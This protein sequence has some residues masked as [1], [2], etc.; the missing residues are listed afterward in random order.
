MN[1]QPPGWGFGTAPRGY[2]DKPKYDFYENV[3]FL[4]DPLSADASRKDKCLAPKI[5]T[6]PRVLLLLVN[7][8]YRCNLIHQNRI[9]DLSTILKK[10][11]NI[12][13]HKNIPLVLEEEEQELLRHKHQLQP[14][15]DLEGM[16]QRLAVI[17]LIRR[18]IPDG[19][20]PK[21]EGH[22]MI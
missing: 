4:D 11:Q 5:G 18:T 3:G 10:D 2:S 17:H 9:Q 15:L 6:E 20:Y 1:L 7:K 19:H 8:I 22:Q 13:A 12:K 14:L 21:V 16:C